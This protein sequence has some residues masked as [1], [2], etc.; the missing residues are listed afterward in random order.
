M[1]VKKHGEKLDWTLYGMQVWMDGKSPGKSGKKRMKA[2]GQS[3]ERAV[4]K[5]KVGTFRR[6]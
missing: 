5:K 2:E 3:G 6:A 1:R 4:P